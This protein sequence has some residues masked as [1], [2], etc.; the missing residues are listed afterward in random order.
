MF[1]FPPGVPPDVFDSY[2][3]KMKEE[4]KLRK[5]KEQLAALQEYITNSPNVS[6][7]TMM[8]YGTLYTELQK[9]KN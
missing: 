5:Q 7:S 4:K 6:L 3:F 8:A 2:C 9:S 1:F